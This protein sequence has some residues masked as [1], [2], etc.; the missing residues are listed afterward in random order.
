MAGVDLGPGLNQRDYIASTDITDSTMYGRE[1][2]GDD[3]SGMGTY[4]DARN[5]EMPRRLVLVLNNAGTTLAKGQ[6]LKW[7][8]GYYGS[9]VEKATDGSRICGY[10]D[11]QR[12]TTIASGAAFYMVKRG[13]CTVLSDGTAITEGDF[14]T[15]G[16]TT[17][18]VKSLGSSTGLSY[19]SVADSAAIAAT[20]AQTAYD[21]TFSIPANSLK[22][23]SRIRVKAVGTV[24]TFTGTETLNAILRL[25]T[26]DFFATGAVDG[27]SGDIFTIEGEVVVR[28][29]GASGTA[30]GTA[31]VSL[32]AALTVT[33]K[34][35]V[36][37]STTIDTTA[38]I[39]VNVTQTA[40]STGETSV[41]NILSVDVLGPEG[42]AGS[43]NATGI[44]MADCAAGSATL[45]RIFANCI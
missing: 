6:A 11:G 36:K 18:Q 34:P 38:A 15:S 30:Y 12:P 3:F 19:T 10:V 21:K 27:T 24:S 7:S 35:I 25:G 45:F 41:L 23:G 4:Q 31:N 8:T 40:S 22:V 20:A 26:T 44:A 16:G 33:A 14:V 32:G 13:P 17:G 43:G 29:I 9:K 37:A 5:S 39:S 28:T 2:D 42:S 1:A